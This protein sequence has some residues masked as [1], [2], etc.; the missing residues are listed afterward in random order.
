VRLLGAGLV[1]TRFGR[2]QGS[3]GFADLDLNL[4]ALLHELV[5]GQAF[6]SSPPLGVLGPLL[7]GGVFIARIARQHL[8]DFD[9]CITL[10]GQVDA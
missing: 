3:V 5:I 6:G 9:H 10:C 7:A 4:E 1:A 8:G 2:G